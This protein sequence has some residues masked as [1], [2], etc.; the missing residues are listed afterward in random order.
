MISYML[1]GYKMKTFYRYCYATVFATGLLLMPLV[2]SA[3]KDDHERAKQ[4][5]DSGD[6]VALEIILQKAQ[7]K[8]PGK[9]LEVELETE[10]DS[11]VYEIEVL[12]ARGVVWE[13]KFDARNGEF[14]KSEK[15][16]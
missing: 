16:D 1:Y 8:H 2:A 14:I 15:E 5:R 3:D 9:V 11:V 13:I 4:L 7:E 10:H 12:D 6:I